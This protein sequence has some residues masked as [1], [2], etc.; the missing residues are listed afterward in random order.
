MKKIIIVGS[1]V[2]A[3]TVGGI[4]WNSHV[5]ASPIMLDLNTTAP[6]KEDLLHVL[7]LSSNEEL[8]NAL[9]DGSTLA[10]LAKDNNVDVQKVISLQVAELTAQI[11]SRYASGNLTDQ[12]YNEQKSEVRD[13]ITQS[14]HGL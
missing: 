10:D 12:Q 13:L 4:S 6:V 8:Y 9:Y 1:M 5:S 11:D 3:I 7:K 14:V 2:F